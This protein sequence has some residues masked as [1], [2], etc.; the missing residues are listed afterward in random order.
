MKTK[1]ILILVIAL[2]FFNCKSDKNTSDQE[3]IN[4]VSDSTNTETS[5]INNTDDFTFADIKITPVNH[6][7]LVIT[8]QNISIYIDPVGND[9]LYKSFQKP[10]FILITD[11]HGDHL[12]NSTLEAVMAPNTIIIGPEAVKEKLSK[13]LISNYKVLSNG[14]NENF[15]ISNDTLNI[16][17]IPMYNLREDA[18]AYHTKGRGNGYVLTLNNQR[19]YISGDT[20]DILEMRNLKNIDV[21]LVCMNLPYTMTIESAADAVLEF[22]PKKILP[23]HYRGTDGFSDVESFKNVV[24]SKNKTIEVIQLDWYN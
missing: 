10:D 17:A 5:Q 24:N 23:Y 2:F 3:V 7:S 8:Y 13:A 11:I 20:E 1:Y 6:A 16:E 19:I 15:S 18:L 4:N 21:A 9:S 12:D 22:M 14:F